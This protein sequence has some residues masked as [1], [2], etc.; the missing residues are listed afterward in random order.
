MVFLVGCNNVN[1]LKKDEKTASYV[2]FE[3]KLKVPKVVQNK[4]EFD[5]IAAFK[6]NGTETTLFHSKPIIESFIIKDKRGEV[7]YSK[8]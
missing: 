1:E 2:N 7:I 5:I 6:N 4:Q 8:D 3:L